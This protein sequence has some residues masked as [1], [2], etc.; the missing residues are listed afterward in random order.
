[1]IEAFFIF[2]SILAF[3]GIACFMVYRKGLVDEYTRDLRGLLVQAREVRDDLNQFMEKSWQ[4]SE[5]ITGRL[6]QSMQNLPES[7]FTAGKSDSG[8]LI[9]PAG[10]ETPTTVFIESGDLSYFEDIDYEATLSEL[11][12]EAIMIGEAVPEA[13][14]E[15]A[16]AGGEEELDQEMLKSMHPY[17]AVKTLRD[18]GHG[19][20]EIAIILNRGQGEITLILNLLEKKR[21]LS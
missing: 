11:Q 17:L 14:P 7:S 3:L 15:P 16:Q 4:L 13:D 10:E 2:F 5:Q 18:R 6:D 19:V 12:S 21:A 9:T 8:D 20:K 1:M